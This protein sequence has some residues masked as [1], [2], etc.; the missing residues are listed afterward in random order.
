MKKFKVQIRT[1]NYTA[2]PLRSSIFS[3]KRAIVRLGSTTDTKN[4]FPKA[5][6]LGRDIIEINTVESI[7]NS[8]SKLRMKDRFA[9]HG[10]PQANWFDCEETIRQGHLEE[11]PY[12]LVA[13]RIYGF[14]GHGM[15]L[16]NNQKELE[17]FVKATNLDGYYFEQFHNYA[18]EYRLHCDTTECF[19][20]WRKL[21]RA[22]ADNRWFFNSSNC[23]WVNEDHELFNRP[24][25]WAEIERDCIN[26]INSVGLTIGAVDVRVQ[27]DKYPTPHYIICEVNSAPAL[28]DLGII[29]YREQITKIITKYE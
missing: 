23:N 27:S 3:S 10:V 18:R 5:S 8:R 9:S 13:K 4:A 24:S 14:K 25:N 12:P 20:T 15:T 1:K 2:T 22:D 6:S 21:R 16:L 11:L 29:K 19:M 28:G 17:D 26:A 7:E